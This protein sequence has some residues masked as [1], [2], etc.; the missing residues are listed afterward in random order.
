MPPIKIAPRAQADPFAGQNVKAIENIIRTLTEIET[1]RQNRIIESNVLQA[2]SRGASAEEL[3]DIAN[4]PVQFDTGL[5]G[6]FQRIASKYARPP[7]RSEIAKYGVSKTLNPDKIT[8]NDIR[9]REYLKAKAEGDEERADK[10]LM[11]SL[12]TIQTGPKLLSPEQRQDLAERDYEEKMGLSPGQL[13]SARK[14]VKTLFETT[15]DKWAPGSADYDR[16]MILDIYKQYRLEN[17]YRGKTT[18]NRKKLDEIFDGQIELWNKHGHPRDSIRGKN[19][20]D[21]D[22]M[23]PKV[24]ELRKE[25]LTEEQT[26]E[27][28]DR[29]I[30]PIPV[31]TYDKIRGIQGKS[32][33]PEA[34]DRKR[35]VE[36]VGIENAQMEIKAWGVIYDAWDRFPRKL[37]DAIRTSEQKGISYTEIMMF[38]EV[39]EILN[40]LIE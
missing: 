13:D 35:L 29:E 1:I 9:M 17:D 36:A 14:S 2:L 22:P 28:W 40:K 6:F 24:V 7:I 15:P 5:P 31:D 33:R 26:D 38:D 16:K 4:R 8:I 37:Q 32:L 18:E 12:V 27:D 10:L 11:S 39:S 21:W 34:P 25:A 23:E 20:F 30:T 19:E 3:M